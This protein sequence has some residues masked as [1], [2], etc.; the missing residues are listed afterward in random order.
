MHEGDLDKNDFSGIENIAKELEMRFGQK[1]RGYGGY[2]GEHREMYSYGVK[3]IRKILAENPTTLFSNE[4]MRKSICLHVLNDLTNEHG[5]VILENA[6]KVHKDFLEK[7]GAVLNWASGKDNIVKRHILETEDAFYWSSCGIDGP[8]GEGDEGRFIHKAKELEDV[9][10]GVLNERFTTDWQEY[11]KAIEHGQ[12]E[13][14]D[15]EDDEDIKKALETAKEIKEIPKES[16]LTGMGTIKEIRDLKHRVNVLE[17]EN[18]EFKE[19]LKE[20]ER[21]RKV[22]FTINT[23]G[24]KEIVKGHVHQCFQDVMFHINCKDNVLLIGPSGCGKTEVA[25]MIAK[26]MKLAFD[27]IS[28]SGGV[29][30]PKIIGRN[31]PNIQ[32]GKSMYQETAFVRFFEK[33]GLFLLDEVDGGDSNVLLCFNAPFSNGTLSVDR[34]KNPV[35]TRHPKFVCIAAANT[36]GTGADRQYVGRNQLDAAFLKRF[37][38]IEM[39]YDRD[40]EF[41]LCPGNEALVKHLHVFRD[42]VMANRLE[43]VV[44]TRFILFANNWMKNGKDLD[45]VNNKLFT[46][47]RADEIQKVCPGY[48]T[49]VSG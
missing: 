34:L 18:E 22:E 16:T 49:K 10:T 26:H 44:D 48:N 24:K 4:A 9:I 28:F 31:T 43:R 45:Y 6:S 7:F 3:I 29:T 38:V 11:T 39:D 46:G 32:T 35:I 14:G 15:D 19:K 17:T 37:V 30:E 33:G 23:N 13:T 1:R 2:K 25:R 5:A 40:L 36:Y 21:T 27:F 20:L 8:I 12:T 47:W 42:R 41:K